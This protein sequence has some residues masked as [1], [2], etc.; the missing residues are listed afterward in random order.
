MVDWKLE[1]EYG[2]SEEKKQERN[3]RLEEYCWTLAMEEEND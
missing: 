2:L 1:P 3:E